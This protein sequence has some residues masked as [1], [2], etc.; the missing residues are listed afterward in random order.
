MVEEL[1]RTWA[2]GW[3]VSRGR[4]TPEERPWGL[5][6]R[7][8]KEDQVARHVLTAPDATMVRA[9]AASVD[10]PH[11]WLKVPAEPPAAEPWL[12]AGWIV[13]EEESGHLMATGLRRS[14]RSAPEGYTPS[15]DTQDGV[16]LIEVHDG[17]GTLAAQAR[18][19]SSARPSSST[20]S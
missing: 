19:P 13:D 17:A 6:V 7:V 1:M 8:G 14:G 20:G 15:A 10:V 12:P 5:Y 18:W 11:T 4:P 16:V 3:A 2:A 9:A